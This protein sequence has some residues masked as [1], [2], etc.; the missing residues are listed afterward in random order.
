MK[1][2]FVGLGKMGKNLAI[3]MMRN[4]ID[5]VGFDQNLESTEFEE[6][7]PLIVESIE[8]LVDSLPSPK[9]VWVMVPS[10]EITKT[11]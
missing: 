7:T 9:I 3:N 8:S 2:G 10:G 11:A 6:Q 4:D 5:V 1:I